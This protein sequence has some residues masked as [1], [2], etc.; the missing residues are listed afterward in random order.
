MLL[1]I[2]L[3]DLGGTLTSPCRYGRTAAKQSKTL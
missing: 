1:E 2:R 3:L